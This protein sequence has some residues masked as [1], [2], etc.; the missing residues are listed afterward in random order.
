MEIQCR[1][2]A[3]TT[4][5]FQTDGHSC[6][7][8]ACMN[9]YYWTKYHRL[10]TVQDFTQRDSKSLRLFI[11]S[12]LFQYQ[13]EDNVT[14]QTTLE[15]ENVFLRAKHKQQYRDDAVQDLT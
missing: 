9:A 7:P 11:A 2:K 4:Y 3:H 14:Q 10:P 6:G 5:P 12:K 13:R 8:F 1:Y 15:G